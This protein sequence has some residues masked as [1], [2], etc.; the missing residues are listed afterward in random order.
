MKAIVY[1]TAAYNMTFKPEFFLNIASKYGE[2]VA[3][4]FCYKGAYGALPAYKVK[5]IVET[6]K[7]I[8]E[9]KKILDYT[10]SQNLVKI[11]WDELTPMTAKAVELIE[12]LG[13]K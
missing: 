11:F 3:V 5:D 12:R 9:A 6:F 4:I 10:S 8:S 13:Q 2:D 1:N 7:K